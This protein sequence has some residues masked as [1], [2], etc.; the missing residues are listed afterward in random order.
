MS[1]SAHKPTRHSSGYQI[2]G[3]DIILMSCF[4][5]I[6]TSALVLKDLYGP[7]ALFVAW[8]LDPECILVTQRHHP[9]VHARGDF[10]D[11]NI[12]ELIKL[13]LQVD[14]D[15][16]K[17]IILTGAP[18]CPD[19]SVIRPDAPGRSG[20]EGQKFS[21]FS[22]FMKKIEQSLPKHRVA[23][24]IENVL[25]QDRG[26]IDFF[27]KALDAHPVLVDSA[28]YQLIS[29]P[30]L[31]WTRIDW[32]TIRDH[33][34][35]SKPLRWGKHQKIYR[36]FVDPDNTN[37]DLQFGPLRLHA[38]VEHGQ[39]LVPCLTTPAPTTAGR[40]APKRQRGRLDPIAK[41]RWLEHGRVFAPW[42]YTDSAML[43]DAQG[44]AHLMTAEAKEVLRM[45][46]V[47]YTKV[48]GVGERSRRRLLANG[49]H[50]GVARFMMQLVVL[51]VLCSV[52]E[53]TLVTGP[54]MTTL[55]WMATQVRPL[56]A[57]VGPG[58]TTLRPNCFPPV[59]DRASHWT[60]ASQARH[61]LTEPA[62]IA[63]G[64]V[65]CLDFQL[66]WKHDLV[67][68]RNEIVIEV[69]EM[70]EAWSDH[71][72]SWWK[73]LPPHIQDVYWH[74][75]TKTYTQ[76]PVI[77]YLL[78]QFGFPELH[79]LADDLQ[80]GFALTGHLHRGVGWRQRTDDRYS[81][82]LSLAKYREMNKHYV[83]SRLR[84]PRVDQHWKEMLDELREEVRL[85][86]MS[87]PFQAP[88]D[89]PC[90]A[91]TFDDLPL[92]PLPDPDFTAA[93][94]FSVTQSDKI[95]RCEDFRRSFL[96]QTVCPRHIPVLHGPSPTA[97][98]YTDAF[99]EAGD[100]HQRVGH[101]S[102]DGKWSMKNCPNYKNG[103][104][105]LCLLPDGTSWY[106]A[107]QVPA[108]VLQAFCR[109]RA[110]IYF[111]EV[112]A[113]LFTFL[114]MRARLPLL[115]IALIDNRGGLA[116]LTKGYGKDVNINNL[117]A[118]TWRLIAHFGWNIHFE[119]VRSELNL[120]D[121]VSRF[122][123]SEAIDLG[124]QRVDLRF[125]ELFGILVRAVVAGPVRLLNALL[126]SQGEVSATKTEKNPQHSEAEEVSDVVQHRD[127]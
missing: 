39:A 93:F 41:A 71:T 21:R 126:T 12:E 96:N 125:N 109:R 53:P 63:P 24:L 104:G 88:P 44:Q 94:C 15:C 43:H 4:D 77:L 20:H 29:R 111:L 50:V 37:K 127:E 122:E 81:F 27:S 51:S 40:A 97:V 8:E 2:S 73:Q 1:N 117:L 99:F 19:F 89:W 62:E 61:P 25:L 22:T 115:M 95:R 74:P 70:I 23:P 90:Q 101:T 72:L 35:T 102:I 57:H 7:L 38:S 9:E 59:P 68:I 49:W 92:R 11:E 31:W 114:V 13:V 47:E 28:D 67:R 120:G 83:M 75:D 103:W 30:R 32:K 124:A 123:F 84:C 105:F 42:Q 106:A 52:V 118:V 65:Q 64:F 45:L 110:F 87:G 82:P 69:D 66:K 6:G 3:K 113:Q 34:E 56:P 121:A 112:A 5:G 60:C 85:G 80:H 36:L 86:R 33:P 14:P 17:I 100:L 26:E 107:G 10:D 98:I 18:P 54:R 78:E 79:E 76:I 46:P 116:A 119:W 58:P 16:E 48:D 108:F 55:Q 91:A